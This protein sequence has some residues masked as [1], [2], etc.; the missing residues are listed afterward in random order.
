M[1]ELSKIQAEELERIRSAH[2]GILYPEKVVEAARDEN[3]PL[4]GAFEWED[5]VAAEKYRLSQARYL[6]RH[7]RV[8]I[9]DPDK[10]KGILVRKYVSLSPDRVPGNNAFRHTG[11]VLS[12]AELYALMLED[13]KNELTAFRK[14]YGTLKALGDILDAI[15]QLFETP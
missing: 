12:D 8:E 7:V 1:S 15:D 13:A 14:K 3:S 5:T 9:R 10:P 11:D 6:I 4:H 2:G